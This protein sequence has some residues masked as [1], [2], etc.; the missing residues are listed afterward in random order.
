MYR[1]NQMLL[2]LFFRPQL[3]KYKLYYLNSRTNSYHHTQTHTRTHTP[4]AQARAAA[5][6]R[7][8]HV[9]ERYPKSSGFAHDGH[10]ILTIV[11]H[12]CVRQWKGTYC[13]LVGKIMC[14]S[15]LGPWPA[16]STPGG[17]TARA[18]A[19]SPNAITPKFLSFLT[20]SLLTLL[21]SYYH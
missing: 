16:A 6:R 8:L 19:R 1:H 2:L 4:S 21:T 12:P 3:F 10:V 17:L 7:D 14:S 9:A 20:V 13:S 18:T 15:V 5:I 11:A